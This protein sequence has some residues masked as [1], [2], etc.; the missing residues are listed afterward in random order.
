MPFG[1][2][3]LCPADTNEKDS[4]S[5][6]KIPSGRCPSVLPA[7]GQNFDCTPLRSVALRMTGW[8]VM[9]YDHG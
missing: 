2:M 1:Q 8:D 6:Y 3:M 7:S 5:P 9:W 4:K